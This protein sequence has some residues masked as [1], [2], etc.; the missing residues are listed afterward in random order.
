[1][2]LTDAIGVT[3][4][5]GLYQEYYVYYNKRLTKAVRVLE[6]WSGSLNL[7]RMVESKNCKSHDVTISRR[8]FRC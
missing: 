3:Y 8:D 1:M 5:I 6:L 7:V 2:D 4:Y